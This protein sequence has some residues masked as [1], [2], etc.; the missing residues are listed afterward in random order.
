MFD[1]EYVRK[2]MDL[3][4]GCNQLIVNSKGDV[5]AQMPSHQQLIEGF[6]FDTDTVIAAVEAVEKAKG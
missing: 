6:V 3:Y 2:V 1:N 4:P 5:Y